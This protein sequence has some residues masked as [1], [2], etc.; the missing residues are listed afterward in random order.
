MSIITL[1]KTKIA[2]G[3]DNCLIG[4][5]VTMPTLSTPICNIGGKYSF[6]EYKYKSDI[7]SIIKLEEPTI[8]ALHM[9]PLD[10]SVEQEPRELEINVSRID[11]TQ[12]LYPAFVMIAQE[13]IDQSSIS[14]T[15][16]AS[17]NLYRYGA[18]IKE[19]EIASELKV[20]GRPYNCKFGTNTK[21]PTE[22][23]VRDMVAISTKLTSAGMVPIFGQ[24]LAGVNIDTSGIPQSFALITSPEAVSLI[25]RD[26]DASNIQSFKGGTQF[27]GSKNYS[28]CVKGC[29][30]TSQITIIESRNFQSEDTIMNKSA[31]VVAGDSYFTS[32]STPTTDNISSR[33]NMIEN[34]CGLSRTVNYRNP[35]V[36][37]VTRE[38]GVIHAKFTSKT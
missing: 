19:T 18:Q 24:F 30:I 36:S 4:R 8:T 6:A 16:I 9:T 27:S 12:K 13:A 23:T 20:H 10:I 25:L 34:S 22:M 3:D 1:Q 35:L 11:V 26:I 15:Y 29:E 32:T 38:E 21:L 5:V 7:Y 17:I 2:K 31:V 14:L 33:S 37:G 28:T